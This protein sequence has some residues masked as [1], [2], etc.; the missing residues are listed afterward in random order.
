MNGGNGA[1]GGGREPGAIDARVRLPREL[2]PPDASLDAR[3]LARYEEILYTPRDASK[4]LED[5]F[6]DMKD[7]HIAGAVLHAEYEHGDVAEA[8]NEAVTALVAEHDEFVAG[9]G[10]VSMADARV[11]TRV[12][13]ASA[14]ARQGLAG[15][16]LQPGFFGLPIDAREL[17]PLYAKAAEEDLIV[18]VHTGVNYATHRPIRNEHPLQLDQVACDFPGLRLVAC[19]AG[20]PFVTEMTAV[21]RRHSRVY[22][23]FGGLA[24]KYVGRPGTGWDPLFGMMDN[25]LAGQVL[26]A[27]DWPVFPMSRAVAEWEALNLRRSTLDGLFRDNILGLL[28]DG[29]HGP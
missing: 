20:W 29:E 25:L 11:M 10:T 16:N 21:A 22:V 4:T 7:A 12:R 15:L 8:L 24:P 18:F 13:Q 23:D 27:S 1:A 26:F 9:I 14:V 2:R 19:H 5:L 6:T 17:Y 3:Y 28:D